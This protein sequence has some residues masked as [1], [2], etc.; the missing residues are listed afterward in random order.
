L[1]AINRPEA[2]GYLAIKIPISTGKADHAFFVEF[3]QKS[4]WDIAIPQDAILIHEYESGESFLQT[5]QGGPQFLQGM[6]FTHQR[7]T[8]MVKEIHGPDHQKDP[9][10][11]TAQIEITY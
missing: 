8:I 4:F 9:F 11:S 1:A 10:A 3:R 2:N 6:T 7:F 5:K